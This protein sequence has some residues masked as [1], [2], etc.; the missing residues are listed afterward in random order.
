MSES[1]EAHTSLLL[2]DGTVLIASGQGPFP[3]V[4]S[5]TEIYDPTAG[6]FST[7]GAVGTARFFHTSTLLGDGRVVITGGS[8]DFNTGAPIASVE[9]FDPALG[10]WASLP[11]MLAARS[12]QT[13]SLLS[14]GSILIF[15]GDAG[16]SVERYDVSLAPAPSVEVAAPITGR[17]TPTPPRSSPMALF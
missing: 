11:A 8:D 10:V 1:R 12:N 14:D 16:G 15:G 2:P 17:A 6:T 3:V 13:A 9:I 7:V 5:S 4:R